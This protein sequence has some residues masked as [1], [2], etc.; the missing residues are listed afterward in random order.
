MP[1]KYLVVKVVNGI[2]KVKHKCWFC[3]KKHV[4]DY[5]LDDLGMKSKVDALCSDCASG[6]E[7][8]KKNNPEVC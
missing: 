3:R 5:P 6:L 8:F 4:L 7:K 2:A 1:K